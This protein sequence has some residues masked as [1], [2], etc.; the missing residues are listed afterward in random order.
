M[1][2]NNDDGYFKDDIVI[3]NKEFYPSSKYQSKNWQVASQQPMV[4][5]GNKNTCINNRDQGQTNFRTAHRI[6]LHPVEE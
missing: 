2:K 6:K 4:V 1:A 5:F 3:V